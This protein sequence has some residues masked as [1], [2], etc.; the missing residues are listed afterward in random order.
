MP[1][2]AVPDPRPR[3][4]RRAPV[5]V[6]GAAIARFRSAVIKIRNL[7]ALRVLWSRVGAVLNSTGG[8]TTETRQLLRP[9]WQSLPTIIRQLQR[10]RADTFDHLVRRSGILRFRRG[11]SRFRDAVQGQLRRLG[12]DWERHRAVLRR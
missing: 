1:I 5:R 8:R 4:A 6:P 2:E 10:E 3:A 9:F 7:L 12:P 11:D